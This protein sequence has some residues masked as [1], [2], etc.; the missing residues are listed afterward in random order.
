MPIVFQ[1]FK[2]H[3]TAY[4]VQFG[5]TLFNLKSGYWQVEL[6]EASKALIAFTVGHLRFCKCEQMPFWL[7]IT[8]MTFQHL[9]ETC[10]GSLQLC[11]CIIYLDDIIIFAA[12]QKEHLERLL[13]VLLWLWTARL[14]L[15]PTKCKFFKANVVYFGTQNFKGRYP[16][17]WL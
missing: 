4:R 9:M 2:I 14:K 8:S 7:I 16:N 5:F 12:T 3:W 6:E 15:Q 13:A 11:W 1:E 10:F 17:W